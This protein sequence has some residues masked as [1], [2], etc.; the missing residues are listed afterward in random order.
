MIKYTNVASAN[1]DPNNVNET[2]WTHEQMIPFKTLSP[3]MI[4]TSI[5]ASE[6]DNTWEKNRNHKDSIDKYEGIVSQN[7]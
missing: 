3:L 7:C 2:H 1:K 5:L 6:T 4:D